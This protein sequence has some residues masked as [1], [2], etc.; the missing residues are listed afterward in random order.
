MAAGWG[1]AEEAARRV[2][3]SL[4]IIYSISAGAGIGRVPFPS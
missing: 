3:K 1:P 4:F 2:F